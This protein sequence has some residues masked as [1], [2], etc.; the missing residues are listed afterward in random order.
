[1]IIQT[2]QRKLDKHHKPQPS[3]MTKKTN[4]RYPNWINTSL[5]LD[6]LFF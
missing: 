5:E 6:K 2:K 4:P 3:G 1:M